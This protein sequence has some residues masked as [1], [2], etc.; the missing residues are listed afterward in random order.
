MLSPR[1]IRCLVYSGFLPVCLL[2][3]G[4]NVK[5]KATAPTVVTQAAPPAK[6][7]S[8][9]PVAKPE[10]RI[11]IHYHRQDGNYDGINL[12]TW[13]GYNKNSPQQNAIA[14]LGRDAFGS[15]FEIDRANYGESDKIGLIPRLGYDWSHKDGGDKFWRPGMGNDVWLVG[16]KDEV[17][18]QKPD[19]SPRVEA[20]YVDA[21]NRII[22]QLTDPAPPSARVFIL[23]QA[24]AAHPVASASPVNSATPLSGNSRASASPQWEVTPQG[25]LDLAHQQYRIRVEGF[26]AAVPL[27]PRGILDNRELYFDQNARLGAD[28]TS[29]ST[30]FR[31]FAPTAKSVSL[32][33]YDE[34]TGDKGRTVQPLEQRSKGLWEATVNGDLSGKFYAYLLDGPELNPKREVVD[35]YAV[36][37]VAS[38]TRARITDVAPAA[39]FGPRVDSPTDMVIYEMHV[40]DF[41]IDPHSGVQQRG[42]YQGFTEPNT[43]LTENPAIRTTLDSLSELGVTHVQLMPVQ[44][45]KDDEAHP[46][47]NWGYITEGYFSPEGMYAT[48]PNDDSRVRELKALVDAL[49]A[50]G[51]GVIMDVVYNHTADD[52]P[53]QFIDPHYYYRHM[54]D[55]SLANGAACGNEFRSE[56]PMARKFILDSLKFWVK[57]YGIDGFRFDLMAL[58]DQETMRQAE[59]DLREINP[60]IVLYGE[61]WEP[62]VSPLHEMTGKNALPTM[63]P[64][65]AF[66]DDYRNALK[67]SPA[68]VDPGWIQNGSNRDALKA[69]MQVSNWLASPMQSINY[70]TCHD[71]LVLWDK[72]KISMPGAPDALLMETMKLGYLALYTSQ[73]VPLILGG[74]EFARSK[75]GD[76]NSYVAPDSVNEV[77]W[78]LKQKNLDLFNYTRDVIA[79]RKAHPAFRLRTR[80]DVSKRLSFQET[81]DEKTLMFTLDG[82]GVAGETWSRICVALNSNDSDKADLALPPGSWSVALDE[83]GAT[84]DERSVSGTVSVPP[85]SG[86]VLYQR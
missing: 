57:E 6:T 60:N 64:I 15:V 12:W 58:I 14:P 11:T 8:D 77:D 7:W 74:E 50:R 79:L 5:Q 27:T 86:L 76:N 61:P 62:G 3:T 13:D 35:P 25:P 33:L 16:G 23:D 83:K 78:S 43:R 54:S 49:H 45:F 65:G 85:K 36:N 26:G 53:F 67:G 20:A 28:Y 1:F 39:Q 59:H 55:G 19:I 72:L 75:G 24:N 81:P 29:Q 2:F 22:L 56:A 66:N 47:Y 44:D 84:T 31:I 32:V 52:A 69:A 38:S 82:A 41:S 63:S 34:A 17:F 37:T 48:N 46:A 10:D 18:A 73:G 71:D 40:R 9:I 21:P 30:T 80:E 4:C 42:L 70:M 68:G 51:I